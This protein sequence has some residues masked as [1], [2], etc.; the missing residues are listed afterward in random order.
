M[1]WRWQ[2]KVRL[3]ASP[4]AG[5]RLTVVD[6]VGS[7]PCDEKLTVNVTVPQP[8][9]GAFSVAV[10]M[11]EEDIA[12]ILVGSPVAPSHCAKVRESATPETTSVKCTVVSTGLPPSVG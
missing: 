10:A 7:L 2:T 1:F 12:S 9:R 8:C 5:A 11:P 6:A 4:P 3:V